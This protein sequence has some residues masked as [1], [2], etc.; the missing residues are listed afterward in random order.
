MW[1]KFLLYG[2]PMLVFGGIVLCVN[3]VRQL[4]GTFAGS[5]PPAVLLVAAGVVTGVGALLV[6]AGLI[7][8]VV[9][10]DRRTHVLAT[11]EDLHRAS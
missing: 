7:G 5:H 3:V 4:E 9:G 10:A 2:V 1:R 6:N 8:A 11:A